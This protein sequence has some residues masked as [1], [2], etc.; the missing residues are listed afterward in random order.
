ME[1]A[2]DKTL[3]RPKA[4]MPALKT[5]VGK[6]LR[7]KTYSILAAGRPVVA[8]IDKG[9]EVARVVGEA[10][11]GLA[12][13]PDDLDALVAAVENLVAD[14]TA[15]AEMGDAGRRWAE[16]WNSPRQV[17]ST[18]ADLIVELAR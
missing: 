11:A 14:P 3:A 15:L 4:A 17:A 2:P 9:S 12:V 16:M 13:P 8:S 10:G 5:L 7:P 1:V 6:H 18:Y